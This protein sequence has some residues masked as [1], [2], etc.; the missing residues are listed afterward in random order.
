MFYQPKYQVPAQSS[1]FSHNKAGKRLAQISQLNTITGRTLATPQTPV[2][3][4]LMR[5]VTETAYHDT[6]HLPA[7]AFGMASSIGIAQSNAP[8]SASRKPNESTSTRSSFQ[9]LLK[10]KISDRD[11]LASQLRRRASSQS[12]KR[13]LTIRQ[14]KIMTYG[15]A[16]AVD[17]IFGPKKLGSLA[18][19][20]MGSSGVARKFSF[21]YGS[22]VLSLEPEPKLE[23]ENSTDAI[24]GNVEASAEPYL[25]P[26]VD[27]NL[28]TP[29]RAN[30]PA[31]T[32]AEMLGIQR[33][34][35]ALME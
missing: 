3:N 32:F 19:Y 12:L 20:A 30:T 11:L 34:P 33:V 26:F 29:P 10:K 7:R 2:Q 6:S 24:S 35:T 5:D 25:H 18:K 17:S 21:E 27:V 22:E 23:V 9:P 16:N 31:Q 4:S 28:D 8:R 13:T 1:R 15:R 14:S